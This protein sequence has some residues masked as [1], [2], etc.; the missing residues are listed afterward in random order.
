MEN[1]LLVGEKTGDGSVTAAE[2]VFVSWKR[3]TGLESPGFTEPKAY[4]EDMRASESRRLFAESRIEAEPF[5]ATTTA[6]GEFSRMDD[7]LPAVPVPCVLSVPA[8][9]L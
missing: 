3:T 2:P 5:P 6:A 4:V 7:A 9:V 1:T 8:M